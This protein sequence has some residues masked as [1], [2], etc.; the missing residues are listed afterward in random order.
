[1]AVM[2][3]S[4]VAQVKRSSMWTRAFESR[5]FLGAMFMVLGMVWL[6]ILSRWHPAE[7]PDVEVES[8]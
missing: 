2:A 6:L 3:E 1:M 4:A 8:A 7:I 5:N